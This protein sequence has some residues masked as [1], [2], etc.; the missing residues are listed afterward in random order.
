M[1][2][3]I[4]AL[5]VCGALL[6]GAQSASAAATVVWQ[7]P[8]LRVSERLQPL[9]IIYKNR[10]AH[11]IRFSSRYLLDSDWSTSKGRLRP[12]QKLVVY[13]ANSTSASQWSC[14]TRLAG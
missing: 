12:L 7:N 1:R 14:R 13:P 8:K 10:I 4:V 2:A 11:A 6:A 5:L 3:K 9:E